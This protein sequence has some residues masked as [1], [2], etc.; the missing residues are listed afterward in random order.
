M[1]ALDRGVSA[2]TAAYVVN[3]ILVVAT[4][5]ILSPMA[6]DSKRQRIHDCCGIS[7]CCDGGS[8][9]AACH[10][11][12]DQL[13]L[14]GGNIL[15]DNHAEH[16]TTLVRHQLASCLRSMRVAGLLA[17]GATSSDSYFQ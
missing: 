9:T 16:G 13:R 2:V 12:L 1:P 10:G 8:A 17:K 7:V 3:A 15:T 6:A 4:N 5:Q 14:G 11:K